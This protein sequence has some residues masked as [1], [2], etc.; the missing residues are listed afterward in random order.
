VHKH[1]SQTIPRLNTNCLSLSPLCW[2][3]TSLNSMSNFV[4][5]AICNN[6]LM[7][8]CTVAGGR[9]NVKICGYSS[10]PFCGW[11]CQSNGNG[12]HVEANF[13]SY[14]PLKLSTCVLDSWIECVSS[15]HSSIWSRQDRPPS[16]EE[17]P[18]SCASVCVMRVWVSEV[19]K[20]ALSLS[21]TLLAHR[22]SQGS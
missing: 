3:P 12:T 10:T 18:W 22:L 5:R 20:L 19:C 4:E 16:V 2:N 13:V 17:V 1:K 6:L 11:S 7:S 8:W 15:P 21:R 14:C 9:E